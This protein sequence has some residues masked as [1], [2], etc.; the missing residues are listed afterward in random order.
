MLLLFPEVCMLVTLVCF[1]IVWNIWCYIKLILSLQLEK[2]YFIKVISKKY[3]TLTCPS[4][5]FYTLFWLKNYIIWPFKE[6]FFW[7]TLTCIFFILCDQCEILIKQ[8]SRLVIYLS[9]S[10]AF[11]HCVTLCRFHKSN[12]SCKSFSSSD[13]LSLILW[14]RF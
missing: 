4:C 11:Y 6:Q 14:P 2:R 5:Q 1:G 7:S 8:F 9:I 13:L 12:S 10:L 3:L